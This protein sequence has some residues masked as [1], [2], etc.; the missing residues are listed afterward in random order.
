MTAEEQEGIRERLNHKYTFGTNFDSAITIF[1]YVIARDMKTEEAII[2][3]LN[4]TVPHE[5]IHVMLREVELNCEDNAHG[6][7]MI[8]T[9]N[10]SSNLSGLGHEF[11]DDAKTSNTVVLENA[12]DV[13]EEETE[14]ARTEAQVAEEAYKVPITTNEA[15]ESSRKRLAIKHELIG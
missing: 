6:L 1:P 8:L 11:Y 3:K 4:Y 2:R 12:D 9:E 13:E 14:Q 15:R 7:T 5:L 10:I